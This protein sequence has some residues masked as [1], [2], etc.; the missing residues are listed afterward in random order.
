MINPEVITTVS[1][2]KPKEFQM[3]LNIPQPII[4]KAN[5]FLQKI[6][7]DRSSVASE[8]AIS[9]LK[10][11]IRFAQSNPAAKAVT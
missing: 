1:F 2:I 9:G 7:A 3:R 10:E 5:R 11:R 4:V 8:K 6:D